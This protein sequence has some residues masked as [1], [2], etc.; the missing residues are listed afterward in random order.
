MNYYLKMAGYI[1]LGYIA[2]WLLFTIG[3]ATKLYVENYGYPSVT[4]F[5][6]LLYGL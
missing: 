2:L 1:L 3:I 5:M 4:Y 6:K